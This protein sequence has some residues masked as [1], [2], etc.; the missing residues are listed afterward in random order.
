MCLEYY[1]FIKKDLINH[2]FFI[3]WNVR[4]E[5]IEDDVEEDGMDEYS[6]EDVIDCICTSLANTVLSTV[7]GQHAL[8]VSMKQFSVQVH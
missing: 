3:S 7:Q 8:V 4:L 1:S 6:D 5:E 2:F